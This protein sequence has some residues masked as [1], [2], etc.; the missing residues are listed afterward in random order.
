[1]SKIEDSINTLEDL[2]EFTNY[3]L[4]PENQDSIIEVCDPTH[5][6][7][8]K[9][10]VHISSSIKNVA[11]ERMIDI[12]T[13]AI[14]YCEEEDSS[15]VEEKKTLINESVRMLFGKDDRQKIVNF[16]IK[17]NNLYI[18]YSNNDLEIIPCVYWV[19]AEKNLCGRMSRLNGSC[20]YKWIRT[21]EDEE[22]FKEYKRRF[23]RSIYTV[24][25][26]I[27]MQLIYHGI[28]LYKGL[29]FNELNC[30]SFDIETNGMEI[31]EDSKS[32]VIV[33]THFK[34]L[35]H[36]T[37]QFVVN[38]YESEKEMIE[39]FNLYIEETNPSIITGHNIFSYDIP[40]LDQVAQNN[41]TTLRLGR[42]GST[43]IYAQKS[44]NYRVD[45]SQTWEY[46][47]ITV[48]GRDIID[49]MFLAVKYDIGRNFPSW[50]LK[51]II[52]T[53]G[54]VQEGRQFYDAS[55]IKDNW[56]DLEEREKIINYCVFDGE[57]SMRI[58]NLMA[59][60]F[61]YMTQS[62]PKTFQSV[63][64]SASGSWLNSIMVRAYLQDNHSIAKTTESKP[65]TGGISFGIPG[66][67]KNCFKIDVS[68]L[69]PSIMR[70]WKVND[71]KKDPN[72]VFF[73][74]VDFNTRERLKNKK[75]AKET[76]DKLYTD[77]EQSQKIFINSAYGL[78]GTNRVNYNN[79][80]DADFIT[81]LGRRILSQTMVWA[82]GKDVNYWFQ[83]EFTKGVEGYKNKEHDVQFEK[84]LDNLPQMHDF[85]IVNADTDSITIKKKD[86]S[87]FTEEERVALIEEINSLLPEM[88]KFEDDGYFPVMVVTKAKNYVLYDGKKIKYK[89]S[90]FK[91]AK[92]EP[93][94]KRLMKDVI[95]QGLIY[96]TRD[97]K[98]IFNEYK[99]QVLN[100]NKDN[101][102]D[103]SV[104]K[105]IT[106]TLFQ[107]DR[108][109]ETKVVDAIEGM[110]LRVGDKAFI[111]N[112]VD[113]MIQS[114][115]IKL[116][117]KQIKDLNLLKYDKLITCE[118]SDRAT[119]YSCNPHL[120]EPKYIKNEIL[121]HIDNFN[122]DLN[123]D[124]Y[125]DRCYATIDILSNV[126]DIG[127]L[128]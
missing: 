48:F 2:D 57:D 9:L 56:D 115:F 99:E 118:H 102:K 74:M 21:F 24:S 127:E 119:C 108:A 83:P 39:D 80:D 61:F 62:I 72:N 8:E 22:D 86:E 15:N 32:Y 17:D 40:F 123:V 3:I 18:Y 105:S 114:G 41:N 5:V 126:I 34:G 69:Y 121:K 19:L 111:Y 97:W 12:V 93:A 103:W 25:D 79:F 42:D 52:D 6:E 122:D 28:T 66:V 109:N 90:S 20:D 1:M 124:H 43:P 4:N 91:D 58:F 117:A 81:S 88:I 16:G 45:G 107:S 87:E 36:E 65:V 110:G 14:E 38:D 85:V 11:F 30:V 96:Q 27:E 54:I 10:Y 47:N 78:L 98:E 100:I 60:S 84:Y 51:S 29:N 49:G 31:D 101:L 73:N 23:Y 35:D 53:L 116:K 76:G 67:N 75:L 106:K 37:T 113:G 112:A 55:K 94:L 63:I 82:T 50:G 128:K 120:Y 70:Q 95:E 71:P 104:K 26:T 89:G 64:N 13:G 59:N 125:L 7:T 46:K 77:L 33:A 44:S 68:S 92:K